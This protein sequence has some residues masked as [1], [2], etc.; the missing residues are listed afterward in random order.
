MGALLDC[1]QAM[2]DIGPARQSP[3]MA[4]ADNANARLVLR[5]FSISLWCVR[6]MEHLLFLTARTCCVS[7]QR[8]INNHNTASA[9]RATATGTRRSRNHRWEIPTRA[10]SDG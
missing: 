9:P 2:D 4:D 3:M 10:W 1:A 5:R 6:F 7:R 8:G